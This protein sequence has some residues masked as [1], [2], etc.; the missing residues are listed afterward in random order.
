[1]RSL[2][3]GNWKMGEEGKQFVLVDSPYFEEIYQVSMIK[4]FV[5]NI[6]LRVIHPKMGDFKKGLFKN[7]QVYLL[8]YFYF[9]AP[10]NKFGQSCRH[11]S[12]FSLERFR[13]CLLSRRHCSVLTWGILKGNTD[14]KVYSLFPCT[15]YS[16]DLD[17]WASTARHNST[18]FA[19]IEEVKVSNESFFASYDTLARRRRWDR[20]EAGRGLI[21]KDRDD[22]AA[23]IVGVACKSCSG[24]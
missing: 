6:R 8:Q 11:G 13:N 1:M 4:V 5:R 14:T 16:S 7:K 9:K 3:T 23:H 17:A 2:V 18:N 12:I 20:S 15:W 10:P 19:D 22:V 24:H 21:R